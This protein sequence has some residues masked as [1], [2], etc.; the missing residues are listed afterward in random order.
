MC[1]VKQTINPKNKIYFKKKKKSKQQKLK[2][3]GDSHQNIVY[4]ALHK[5]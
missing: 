3:I 1:R 2:R 5:N 4:P